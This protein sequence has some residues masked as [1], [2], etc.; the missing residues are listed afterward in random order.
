MT[1]EAY[2]REIGRETA[3]SSAR[4]LPALMRLVS[5]DGGQDLLEYALLSAFVALAGMAAFGLIVQGI[6]TTYTSWD[7]STQALW[8]PP[9]PK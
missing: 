8:E 2:A 4:L 3:R 6:N 1:G 9:A 5:D 7:S